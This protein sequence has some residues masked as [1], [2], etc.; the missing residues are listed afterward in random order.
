MHRSETQEDKK[1]SIRIWEGSF[2]VI[3]MIFF[4]RKLSMNAIYQGINKNMHNT[5]NK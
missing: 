2:I 5:I 3:I 1:M 4:F